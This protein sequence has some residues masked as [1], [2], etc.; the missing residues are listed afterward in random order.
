MT[1][2]AWLTDQPLTADHVMQH[3]A[4]TADGAVVVFLG[5]VRR[6]NDG[7]E[8]TGIRYD[9]YRQMAESVLADIAHEAAQ[10]AGGARIA[11][12]HRV[13]ELALGDV[14]VAI[15]VGTPHRAEAYDASRYIIEEIKK[16]L[17]VWKHERYASGEA[18]WVAGLMPAAD[19]SAP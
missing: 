5:T 15:A 9:A 19:A 13:G 3:V 18:G 8:V 6:T 1:V 2:H 17:P 14:S 12:A 7:R 4:D 16:R 10:R 11:V